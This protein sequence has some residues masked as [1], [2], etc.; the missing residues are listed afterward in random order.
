MHIEIVGYLAAFLTTA[1]FFPQ[2]YKTIRTRDTRAISLAMY[3][4]FT[5]GI[6]IWLAYGLLIESWPL[7][8][9]NS[10]TFVMAGTILVLKLK[11]R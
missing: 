5:L 3:V 10:L 2:T 11:E 9:S 1:A 7:I 6:A 4:M 8:F